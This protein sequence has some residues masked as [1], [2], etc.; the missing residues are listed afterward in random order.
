MKGDELVSIDCHSVSISQF[1][2]H[3]NNLTVDWISKRMNF[4]KQIR[5]RNITL[6]PP[7]EIRLDNAAAGNIPILEN[8]ADDYSKMKHEFLVAKISGDILLDAIYTCG[9][10]FGI[11]K[12]EYGKIIPYHVLL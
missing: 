3:V 12:Y 7:A 10:E 2:R 1:V 9:S 6:Y 4:T 11:Q 8:I 5:Y